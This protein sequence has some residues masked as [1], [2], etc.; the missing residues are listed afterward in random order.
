MDLYQHV[1]RPVLFRL[2]ADTAHR[3]AH[4]ALRWPLPWR[5]LGSGPD[6]DPRLAVERHGLRFP[7]PVGL[8]PGFDKDGDALASLQHVGFGFLTPGAI[9]RDYRA[10]NPAPR[11]ARLV[12]Q[13]ALL[14]CMGLPSKG[15]DHAIA[16]LK[17]L[18]RRRVPVIGEVQGVSPRDIL[19]NVAAVQPYVEALEISTVCVNT[20]DTAAN[21]GL[22][23]VVELIQAIGRLRSRPVFVKVPHWAVSDRALLPSFLDACIAAG[24]Q[25]VVASATRRQPSA[26]LSMGMGNLSGRPIFANNLGLV[27]EIASHAG[28]RLSIVASGGVW[29]GRD[30]YEMLS[31]GASLVEIYTAMVY[32]GWMAPA[33]INREL[34]AVLEAEGVP[35]V[36][37]LVDRSR[38]AVASGAR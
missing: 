35:S 24:L 29:S 13:E 31:A 19:D 34:L 30:A 18:Q 28:D 4:L 36:Q 23:T 37:A 33:L 10:G 8:A 20:T 11:L 2:P 15:R 32:R 7:N 26:R 14:N 38:A 12:E 17:A 1:V 5:L 16:N 3:L 21:E 22:P 25:G 6:V 9:L 27:Q